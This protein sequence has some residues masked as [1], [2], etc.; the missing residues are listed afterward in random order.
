VAVQSL[1]I[2]LSEGF[3]YDARGRLP[4]A[5]RLDYRKLTAAIIEVPALALNAR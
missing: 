3:R 2:A 5:S 1:G 4:N